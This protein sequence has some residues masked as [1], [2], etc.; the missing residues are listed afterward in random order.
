MFEDVAVSY[1]QLLLTS[2]R[3]NVIRVLNFI[4][5]LLRNNK[6]FVKVVGVQQLFHICVQKFIHTSRTPLTNSP[7]T[8]PDIFPIFFQIFQ[9]FKINIE[10]A[11]LVGCCPR[12][13]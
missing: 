13:F 5:A 10:T 12:F 2:S 8:L 4:D 6:D 9:Y 7:R 11:L 3:D 1:Y